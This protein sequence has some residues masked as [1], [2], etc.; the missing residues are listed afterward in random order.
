M[1]TVL[2]TCAIC[3][4]GISRYAFWVCNPFLATK[5]DERKGLHPL[6]TSIDPP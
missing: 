4:H 2:S 3:H 1:H 6:N 5:V